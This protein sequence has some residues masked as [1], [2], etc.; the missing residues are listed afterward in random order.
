MEAQARLPG[1]H[2][3]RCV[4]A[5]TVLIFHLVPNLPALPPSLTFTKN[6]FGAGVH[7]FFVLSAFSLMYSTTRRIGR[8][9]WIEDYLVKRYFR[10]APLFY[11][12][13]LFFL[14]F[15]YFFWGAKPELFVIL[16]NVTFLYNP[17]K[18]NRSS[19]PGGHWELRCCSM[20][21]FL[22]SF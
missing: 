22:S 8:E 20:R 7:L 12:M 3:L 15:N 1:I 16:F 13:M 6:Y 14:L 2:G 9:G 5:L 10:I 21:C 11:A 17:I 19:G 18:L 4:A